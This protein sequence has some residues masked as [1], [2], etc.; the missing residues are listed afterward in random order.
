MGWRIEA[1]SVSWQLLYSG[2][3]TIVAGGLATGQY[4]QDTFLNLGNEVD[5]VS[6]ASAIFR[7]GSFRWALWAVLLALLNL[8]LDAQPPRAPRTALPETNSQKTASQK[9][10]SPESASAEQILLWIDQ[11]NDDRFSVR[12]SATDKLVAVGAN[13]IGPLSKATDTG[14]LEVAARAIYVLRELALSKDVETQEKSAR[15]LR[16]VADLPR[17]STARLARNA[18]RDLS[19]LR[20]KQTVDQ[21]VKLGAVLRGFPPIGF[22]SGR[23]T[24]LEIGPAWKGEP[25]DLQLLKWLPDLYKVTFIGPQVNDAWIEALRGADGLAYLAIKNARITDQACLAISEFK[26]IVALDLMYS[27]VTDAG[28]THLKKMKSVRMIRCYGTDVTA[29]AASELQTELANV[30]VDFKRGAFL[31]VGCQQGPL[32]CVVQRVTDQSAAQKAGV[33]VGDIIVGYDQQNVADFD[34]LRKLIARNKV[35]DTVEVKVVRGGSPLLR[36]LGRQPKRKLGLEAE[37][38]PLGL[39]VKKV[40]ADSAAATAGIQAGDLLLTFDNQRITN[41]DQL[42]KLYLKKTPRP[43]NQI[44]ILRHTSV[45]TMK[46]TFG[47]WNDDLYR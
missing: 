7:S 14:V 15:V 16:K 44:Q 23:R 12:T 36:A 30:K 43:A 40:Q 19:K 41:L 21:L 1:W 39:K 31:G 22:A 28:L 27:P 35:G 4:S 25:K 42:Q 13:A 46:V 2:R 17:R 20:Q 34:D 10:I 26:T 9:T 3:A 47:Q 38:N 18:I 11:L 32:P 6:R 24:E 5:M 37:P 29:A 33:Q 45:K 8:P